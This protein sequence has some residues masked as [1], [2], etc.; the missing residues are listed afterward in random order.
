MGMKENFRSAT[1]RQ[2][3]D[4][5]DMHIVCM[6]LG[7]DHLWHLKYLTFLSFS[8]LASGNMHDIIAGISMSLLREIPPVGCSSSFAGTQILGNAGSFRSV[9]FLRLY[10]GVACSEKHIIAIQYE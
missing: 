9:V 7:V 6:N 2:G 3:V 8:F 5:N 1:A 10:S 4:D